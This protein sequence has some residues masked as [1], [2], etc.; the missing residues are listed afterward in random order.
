MTSRSLICTLVALVLT[1]CSRESGPEAPKAELVILDASVLTMN[2]AQPQARALAVKDGK[3]A[4]V[5]GEQQ[6]QSW[7]GNDTRV[8]RLKGATVLPGLI[9]T[10]IHLA[11]GALSLD[12]C[13]AADEQLAL[14]KLAPIIQECAARNPEGWV[15]VENVNGAGLRADARGLDAI[16]ANRPV[17]LWAADG[18][19]G[20]VNSAALKLA[21]IDRNT[22]DPEGGRIDRDRKGG[23]T[24]LVVD[25]ALG[26]VS[27][28]LPQPTPEKREEL[29]LRALHDL[30]AVGVVTF[31]EANTNAETVRTYV[32]LAQQRKLDARV[33]IALESNGAAT[34]EEFT[35]L[36]ALR[37][38]AESQPP[39]RAD[40][41][42]LFE[43]GVME[44]PA[45]TAA[46]L[47]PYLEN[48]KPGKRL[49]PL[50]YE[51]A[52]LTEFVQRAAQ[53]GF[54]V[55]IHVIGDRAT[56]VALDAFAAARAKGSKHTYSLT[57]L[58]L[59]DPADLP[60]FKELDVFASMQLQWG[61]P[62]NYSVE[63]VLPYIG[64]ERQGRLYPAK[65][66]LDAGATIAGASDWNVSTFNPFEAIAVSMSRRNPKEPQRGTLAPDQALTLDQ[67]LAAY[68]MN[69]ARM[70]GREKD[71]GS[72]EP[73]KAADIVVLD[74][75]LGA[76]TSADD[77]RA[78]KVVYTFANGKQLIGPAA[79]SQ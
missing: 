12:A 5:G 52:P 18:H 62:D 37:Q 38:E 25:N 50:Y 29:L 72:L 6:A 61:Q 66:L 56:R 16:I 70:L 65:S 69:A 71:I 19:N 75:Q 49:G 54:G 3:V 40:V 44:Y 10:H 41:I 23:P 43:D 26:L 32:R 4:F 45:Q 67:M 9:D 7:I 39:L 30:A 13:T 36:K 64:P 68:T 14:E 48:G 58:E 28:Q 1:A 78:T 8:L 73:G 33:S 21:G 77:V 20:W 2:P 79:D 60:R 11:M 46:M 47:E 74:R 17:F 15:V 59:V 24:G 63:A 27:A 53:E 55:H 35:R 51:P 22:K 76:S 57:H 31:L 34:D 42:K